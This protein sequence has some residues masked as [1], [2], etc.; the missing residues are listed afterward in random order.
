MF[1]YGKQ[2][3]EH[4]IYELNQARDI[5][6][7]PQFDLTRKTV[8]YLHGYIETPEVES[9]HVIVDAYIKRADHNTLILDWGKLADGN[10]LLDA[11][12]NIKEVFNVN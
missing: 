11:V 9:I 5:M 12:Q 8:L 6:K 10:Y 1:F 7:H 4:Q 3:D 2:F